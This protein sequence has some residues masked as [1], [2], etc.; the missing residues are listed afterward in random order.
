M[1]KIAFKRNRDDFHVVVRMCAK[2]HSRGNRVVVQYA[3][4]AELL[5]LRG[6]HCESPKKVGEC[7]DE[8]L[9]SDRPVVLEFKVDQEIAPIP[10]HITLEQ[11]RKAAKAAVHDPE[12][13]GI[14]AKGV[15][16]K[17]TELTEHLPG[18]HHGHQD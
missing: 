6:I 5:G 15:R 16:Q 13:A 3:K 8:E 14:A 2:S 11:G 17:L 4:Y 9:S 1:R 10:P 12:R 7:W 18:H